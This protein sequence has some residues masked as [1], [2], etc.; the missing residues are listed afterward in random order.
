MNEVVPPLKIWFYTF[1]MVVFLLFGFLFYSYSPNSPYKKKFKK[2]QHLLEKVIIKNSKSNL[3]NVTIV[4]MGSS[5]TRCAFGNNIDIEKKFTKKENKKFT[6]LKITLDGLNNEIATE[7]KF[8]EYI[9]KYP[10]AYLF[11]E[12]NNLNI[13]TENKDSLLSYLKKSLDNLINFIKNS[14]GNYKNNIRTIVFNSNPPVGEPFY[15][16]K[17]DTVIYS[18]LL[19]KKRFVRSFSQNKIANKAYD[20]LIQKKTKIIF[21]EMPRT[22]KLES[23]YIDRIQK[24]ELNNLMKTYQQ[25]F[26]IE[27][28]K[29]PNAMSNSDFSDGGHL[30]YKGAKKYQEWFISK[31]DSIK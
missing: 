7:I 4:F 10:P 9:S 18:E 19:I 29:Y 21:L 16:N 24:I 30:N 8:F 13:D 6:V 15:Q 11:I 31:F 3:S 22:P 17:F 20:A 25:K 26:G 2:N 12:N 27:Y 23:I 1:G 14:L 5:L 28:W